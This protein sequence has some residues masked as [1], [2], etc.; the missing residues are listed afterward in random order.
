MTLEEKVRKFNLRNI[1]ISLA[2]LGFL[3]FGLFLGS[4]FPLLTIQYGWYWWAAAILLCLKLALKFLFLKNKQKAVAKKKR[5]RGAMELSIGTIV[6]IV[7]AMTMLI[8]G[9]V[10]VRTIF[11]GATESV[12]ILSDK[13]KANIVNLFGD[14]NKEVVVLLGQDRT[15]KIKAGADNFGVAVGARTL[16]GSATDRERLKYKITL[17]DAGKDDCYKRLGRKATENLFKQQLGSWLEFDEYQADSSFA[18]I[19]IAVPKGT[20]L[21]TQ[22]V[23]FDVKD[24]RDSKDVGGSF[25]ILDIKRGIF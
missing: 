1:D 23:L 15:A 14:E 11:T 19:L 8:L 24:A 3:F 16:D 13:V 12:N 4:Q 10:F 6:V 7:L 5:K 9:L 18:I 25:F 20:E 2:L 22:K 17:D 21:C